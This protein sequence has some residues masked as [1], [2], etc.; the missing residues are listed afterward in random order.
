MRAAVLV[1]PNRIEVRDVPRPAV[2]PNEVRVR[3]GAVGLCGTDLHIAAG[4]A[5]YHRDALGR[6]IPLAERPQILGHEIAGVVTEVGTAARGVRAG[7][8]V[9]VDQGRTCVGERRQPRCEYCATGDSHQCEHYREHGITGL[10]GGFAEEIV[11]PD[12]NVVPLASDL[13]LVRAALAE[14]L[15]C[16]VHSTEV[17]LRTPARYR[18]AGDG[19]RVRCV[20]ICGAGPSGLLFV[21]YL[22]N[23]V[24]YDGLLLASEPNARRRALAERFGAVALDPIAAPLSEV[25]REHTGGRMAELFIDATGAG[26]VIAAVPE[27]VRK[28]GTVLLYAHGHAGVDLSALNGVQFLEPTML[29][30][31]GASGGFEPDGRPTT[32]VRA[33]RLVEQGRIDVGSLVTHRYHSLDEVP[34]AFAGDHRRPDYVKGV[35]VLDA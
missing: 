23:V 18:L 35:V 8:R 26:E 5:N 6:V 4:H 24:G 9:V 10:P 25:V 29:S 30:P 16:V 11:V 7:E 20:L 22:R 1:A 13:D 33:L 17:L 2:A 32:Y 3:V 28:Q 12:A 19:G 14:P 21:Q 15:G 31:C 27:L 34:A